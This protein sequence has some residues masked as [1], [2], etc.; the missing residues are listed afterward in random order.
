ADVEHALPGSDACQIGELRREQGR[1]SAHEAVVRLGVDRKAHGRNSTARQRMRRNGA[2]EGAL[3]FPARSDAITQ[4]RSR[5]LWSLPGRDHRS[6]TLRVPIANASREASLAMT[7]PFSYTTRG[8]SLPCT[9][10]AGACR[11]S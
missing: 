1:V 8:G 10:Y 6:A 4:K 5:R 7:D 11:R 9:A 2:Q 3:R